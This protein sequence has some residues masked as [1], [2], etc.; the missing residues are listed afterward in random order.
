MEF[1]KEVLQ[2][3]MADFINERR[4]IVVKQKLRKPFF[5]FSTDSKIWW[6]FEGVLYLA[7]LMFGIWLGFVL[8]S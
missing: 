1:S 7:T 3:D 6:A 2:K 5:D 4:K 8:L